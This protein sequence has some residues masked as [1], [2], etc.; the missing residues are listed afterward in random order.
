[1]DT[2]QAYK[3]FNAIKLHF[4]SNSYDYFKYNGK[5]R[6][7]WKSF[8][9]FSGKKILHNLLRKHQSD[10]IEF[11]ATGFAYDKNISWIGDFNTPAI[12]ESWATHKKNMG[13][14]TR[15]YTDEITELFERGSVKEVLMGGD[16]LPLIEKNRISGLTSM[17]TCCILDQIF[18]YINRNKCDHPLWEDTKYIKKYTPFLKINLQKFIDITKSVML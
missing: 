9:K 14:L 10:F 4:T 18:D 6:V 16:Q 17:E 5:S 11:V 1:M 7:T 13:S 15:I 2:F 12:D 3:D 8:E